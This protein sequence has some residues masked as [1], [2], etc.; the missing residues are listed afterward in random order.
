MDMVAGTSCRAARGPGTC[1]P[2]TYPST[3]VSQY[4]ALPSYHPFSGT[5]APST[6]PSTPV[7]QYAALPSYHPFSGTCARSTYPST[8]ALATPTLNAQC[9]TTLPP[10]PRASLLPLTTDNTTCVA[11]RVFFVPNYRC[12]PVPFYRDGA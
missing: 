3:P 1:A 9:L 12:T 8:Q 10:R 7:S 11:L 2:S 6:Y 5:C 4:A